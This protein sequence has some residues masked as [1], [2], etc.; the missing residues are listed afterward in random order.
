MKPQR[1]YHRLRTFLPAN[2]V[3]VAIDLHNHL[4]EWDKQ[5]YDIAW[6]KTNL[7]PFASISQMCGFMGWK[8]EIRERYKIM[9]L[10]KALRK[11]FLINFHKMYEVGKKLADTFVF[12]TK[13]GKD[14]KT[15]E[16]D[17]EKTPLRKCRGNVVVVHEEH[18]SLL[19]Y[20]RSL[21]A[22]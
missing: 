16:F 14:P 10:K 12:L 18:V 17:G 22:P 7:P 1:M 20:Y 21:M 15:V 9:E 4:V 11:A 13:G 3:Q 8:D 2:K 19:E 5:K 6:A